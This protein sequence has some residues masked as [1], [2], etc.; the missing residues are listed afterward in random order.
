[1]GDPYIGRAVRRKEDLRLLT[2]N[3][4]FVDDLKLPG[5][6]HMAVLR[7]SYAHAKI[8]K[9]DVNKARRAKG[10]LAV[11]ASADLGCYN[12]SFPLLVPHPSLQAFTPKPL[13]EGKVLY[14]GEPVAVAV[15]DT[16]AA[17]ED[18]VDLIHVEYEP[19][20]AMVC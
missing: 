10:V 14:V 7:S 12:H 17:A 9:I 2:G 8:A 6:A 5:T 16:R 20:Q 15:A 18:S 19:L 4:N 11:F 1:M 13:A 3:G